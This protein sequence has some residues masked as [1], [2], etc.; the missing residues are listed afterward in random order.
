MKKTPVALAAALLWLAGGVYAAG[1]PGKAPGPGTRD[2]KYLTIDKNSI[3]L[4]EIKTPGTIQIS[5]GTDIL[6]SPFV[7]GT[8]DPLGNINGAVNTIDNL[9]NLVDKV[10][11]IIQKNQPVVNTNINYAGAVPYGITHWGQ[12]Q[13]WSKPAVKRYGFKI[14]NLMG[15]EVVKLVFQVQRTCEGNYQG[16][17]KFLTGVTVEPLNIDVVWGYNVDLTAEVPDSTIANVGTQQD[18]V[19]SM[20]LK[21]HWKMHTSIQD[22][23]YTD[24]FYLQGDGLLQELGIPYR[25][26]VKTQKE[27]NALEEKLSNVK[28]N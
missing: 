20:Q 24:I 28:F 7:S 5:T 23:Q 8:S 25:D 18:P 11:T 13:G 16:K 21:L 26:T 14:K 15:L 22:T 4:E 27:I 17:G 19:A 6:P 1:F 2:Q 3:T 10:F 12:L 9:V